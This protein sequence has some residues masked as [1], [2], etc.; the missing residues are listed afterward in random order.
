MYNLNI[1]NTYT[2]YIENNGN[3]QGIFDNQEQFYRWMKNFR[4]GGFKQLYGQLAN[5]ETDEY[6]S[7]GLLFKKQIKKLVGSGIDPIDYDS[8][9]ATFDE[10]TKIFNNITVYIDDSKFSIVEFIFELNDFAKLDFEH[11][12]YILE[13]MHR[14]IRNENVDNLLKEIKKRDCKWMVGE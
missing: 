9:Y 7:L 13:Y 12:S 8:V 2:I 1:H 11:I 10:W 4:S 5:V 6:C 3:S 14:L